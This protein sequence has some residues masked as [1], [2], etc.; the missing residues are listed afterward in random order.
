MQLAKSFMRCIPGWDPDVENGKRF[1]FTFLLMSSDQQENGTLP[2]LSVSV[3]PSVS[4]SYLCP[5]S[6]LSS[7]IQQK[8]VPFLLLSVIYWPGT[9]PSRRGSSLCLATLWDTPS[10]LIAAINPS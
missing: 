2:F 4:P 9:V 7:L 10:A 1:S 3:S 8:R 6:P 5:L